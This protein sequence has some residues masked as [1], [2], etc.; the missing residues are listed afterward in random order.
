MMKAFNSPVVLS[1]VAEAPCCEAQRAALFEAW[2]GKAAE[3]GAA[4]ALAGQQYRRRWEVYM[5]NT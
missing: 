4:R 1:A 2:R 5:Y 3:Q